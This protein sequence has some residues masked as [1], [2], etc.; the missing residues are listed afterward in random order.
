MMNLLSMKEKTFLE[1][2]AF[3]K[4]LSQ[5]HDEEEVCNIL[6]FLQA[7]DE[8]KK[9]L[10]DFVTYSMRMANWFGEWEPEGWDV[11]CGG[12]PT[13]GPLADFAQPFNRWHTNLLDEAEMNRDM[14]IFEEFEACHELFAS[15]PFDQRKPGETGTFNPVTKRS[16]TSVLGTLVAVGDSYGTVQTHLGKAFLPKYLLTPPDP[17]TKLAL[18]NFEHFH[19]LE[20]KTATVNQVTRSSAGVRGWTNAGPFRKPE[21]AKRAPEIGDVLQVRIQFKGFTPAPGASMPWRVIRIETNDTLSSRMADDFLTQMDNENM[22]P[23]LA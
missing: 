5:D 16:E 18:R 6:E 23:T 19:G 7:S 17:M 11:P 1:Q 2:L 22:W 20:P 3:L 15:A 14:E 13:N 21:K 10:D 4:S 9:A 12:V 8:E